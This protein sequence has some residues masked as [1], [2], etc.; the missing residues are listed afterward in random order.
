MVRARSGA[1]TCVLLVVMVA[2]PGVAFA[3]DTIATVSSPTPVSAFAGR[4]AWSSYDPATRGYRLMTSARGVT[5]T[6]PVRPRRVPFDVDL[7]PDRNGDTVAVYSRCHRDPPGRD[8]AIGNALTQMPDWARGRGCDLYELDFETGR[9]KRISAASSPESSEFLPSIWKS[10]IAFAR[11]RERRR[12]VERTRPYLYLRSQ[13]GARRSRR[14]PGGSRSRLRFCTGKPMRCKLKVEPG[15]TALDLAGR[16]LTFGWDSGGEFG[17]TTAV[18]LET[19]GRSRITRKLLTRTGSGS[20]QGK[21][22]FSPSI[23]A[24]RIFWERTIFGEDASSRLRRYT[25]STGKME[26]TPL[27]PA[28]AQDAF[29]RPV[30]AAAVSGADVFYLIS[31]H[32]LPGEP[33]CTPQSPCNADPGCSATEPCAIRRTQDLVFSAVKGREP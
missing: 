11:V 5:S 13:L 4:L 14:L 1:I 25:I 3:N 32:I 26:E 8:P 29:R 16:R 22:Y 20:I 9:E 21:E 33:G 12:G 2:A 18:Y 30:L 28:A 24:G 7:G 10:R 23:E 15:P 17:P 27:P 19:I 6:L 31:G